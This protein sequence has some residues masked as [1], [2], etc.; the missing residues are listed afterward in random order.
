MADPQTK[1]SAH[2]NRADRQQNMAKQ[3]KQRGTTSAQTWAIPSPDAAAR[4]LAGDLVAGN[5]LCPG[6]GHSPTDRSLTIKLDGTAPDG[7][8]VHS[9]AGDDWRACRD[10]VRTKLGIGKFGHKLI[11]HHAVYTKSGDS[12]TDTI[13]ASKLKA[14]SRLWESA[15]SIIG[16][17]GEAYLSSRIGG[18]AIPQH[19]LKGDQLRWSTQPA[20]QGNL[21]PDSAG[22][23]VARMVD[24]ESR[25]F[26]GIHRTYLDHKAEKLDRRMLGGSGIVMLTGDPDAQCDPLTGL[27]V[28]EGIETALA[29]LVRYDWSPMWATLTAGNLSKFPIIECIEAL[30]IFADHDAN[31]AGKIAAIR[32]AQK[33]LESDRDV[34]IYH[35]VKVASDFADLQ[36]HSLQND[37]S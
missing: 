12:Q 4:C 21:M 7:F 6:P 9:F 25:K 24:P 35:P 14:A 29:A 18:H 26:V 16:T 20:A 2:D 3:V 30:T 11:D 36:K 13:R 28:A 33:W 22:S 34:K 17:Q 32:C 31:H 19:V 27:A 8:L 15:N 23:L 5:I 1:F 10:Y 37:L